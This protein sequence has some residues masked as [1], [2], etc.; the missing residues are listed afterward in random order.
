MH[1]VSVVIAWR[2]SGN[3]NRQANLAAVLDHLTQTGLPIVLADDGKTEGPFNRSAAYNH[4]MRLAP[5][6]VF[7]F[8]E[9]D[10]LVPFPQLE[11]AVELAREGLGLVV[12]FDQYRYL[13]ED[14]SRLVLSGQIH[15]WEAEPEWTMDNGTSIGAVNV[16][17]AESMRWVGQWD[18]TLEGHGYDDN[19]MHRAFEVACGPTR[20]VHGPGHH[21]WHPMAF[22]PWERNTE[23]AQAKNFTPAEVDATMRNR[24]RLREYQAATTPEQ[25]RELTGAPW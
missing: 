12:P 7:V 18:E 25:I 21:L 20:F 14:E 17:S 6:E 4:G 19:V 15:P 3:A 1:D 13:S 23:A 5:A 24:I 16:V 11:A 2:D 22:A 9:A 8:H 10:M